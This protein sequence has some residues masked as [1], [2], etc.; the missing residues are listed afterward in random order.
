MDHD[1]S[2]KVTIIPS[3][4]TLSNDTITFST[5]TLSTIRE[6]KS[7]QDLSFNKNKEENENAYRNAEKSQITSL[8]S[9]YQKLNH[10]ISHPSPKSD[11]R[12]I[13]ALC[14]NE[15]KLHDQIN[16]KI[17]KEN[18]YSQIHPDINNATN[19][20]FI[21]LGAVYKILDF[22]TDSDPKVSSLT[23]NCCNE[24]SLI[25]QCLL[26]QR[27]DKR[28][29]DLLLNDSSLYRCEH[30]G[31][32]SYIPG[33]HSA[34]EEIKGNGTR[35]RTRDAEIT[36]TERDCINNDQNKEKLE[37]SINFPDLK[38]NAQPRISIDGSN[39]DG[40][41]KYKNELNKI[42]SLP[43]KKRAFAIKNCIGN[44]NKV[45][46]ISDTEVDVKNIIKHKSYFNNNAIKRLFTDF[47]TT[48][49]NKKYDYNRI[50]RN[51]NP[52]K[53]ESSTAMKVYADIDKEE[54]VRKIS[55]E[56]KSQIDDVLARDMHF[57]TAQ[58]IHDSQRLFEKHGD[59]Y[60]IIDTV[61]YLARGQFTILDKQKDEL[62]SKLQEIRCT[63][64]EDVRK[65][66]STILY[67]SRD[68]YPQYNSG[69]WL[70][71]KTGHLPEIV[72]DEYRCLLMPRMDGNRENIHFSTNSS[73]R[74]NTKETAKNMDNWCNYIE[75]DSLEDCTLKQ[76]GESTTTFSSSSTEN[77]IHEWIEFLN[78]KYK[79]NDADENI[80]R[81]RKLVSSKPSLDIAR[82]VRAQIANDRRSD[83]KKSIRKLRV[84]DSD[85]FIRLSPKIQ[86]KICHLI[87][88]IVSGKDSIFHHEKC[89]ITDTSNN[90]KLQHSKS[91]NAS[92]VHSNEMTNNFAN[93]CISTKL[94]ELSQD[95]NCLFKRQDNFVNTCSQDSN[96]KDSVKISYENM[97]I[98]SD[99]L[100][101]TRLS[102]NFTRKVTWHII[103][104]NT[105]LKDIVG[106]VDEHTDILTIYRKI[107]ENSENMDWD[108]FQKFIEIL[109]PGQKKLW[110]DICKTISK[111]AKS[112]A[113]DTDDNMEVCIE[114]SPSIN[115]GDTLKTDEVTECTWE[116]VFEL[117]MTLK[118]VETFFLTKNDA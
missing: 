33:L 86:K 87:H 10:N 94:S 101:K 90:E 110:R 17:N 114:I 105:S 98:S 71:D 103:Y 118:D 99:K 67:N 42:E 4:A 35:A 64:F 68:D 26:S 7:K 24:I 102:D 51:N 53:C 49:R 55:Y 45:N 62:F 78:K 13:C 75:K 14:E 72:L 29:E 56:C 104:K 60:P 11:K 46:N 27:D 66:Q 20:P 43:V 79:I 69:F 9:T 12:L 54:I 80:S 106:N 70:F 40:R 47:K 65:E 93:V 48:K 63:S 34:T 92:F 77:F 85:I 76:R 19:A 32:I 59:I 111:E 2:W 73:R 25:L 95:K 8:S 15:K 22:I 82:H 16:K 83:A 89:L 100:E 107:L 28:L 113:D 44:P 57:E 109:H 81:G 37:I 5:R 74:S 41:A 39:V 58:K 1:N 116:I 30:C 115:S 52:D 96:F 21:E 18:T 117:D 6:Q 84:H 108:S 50:A 61:K 3:Q 36:N 97:A 112:I 38:N 31:V 88:K 91:V 23:N